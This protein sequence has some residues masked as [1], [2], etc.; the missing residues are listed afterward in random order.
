MSVFYVDACCD[1]SR[2]HIKTLGVE[3]VQNKFLLDKEQCVFDLESSPNL[4]DIYEKF[5]AGVRLEGECL[6]V[7]EFEQ[8]FDAAL[9]Q[10]ENVV[11]VH[12]SSVLYDHT[13]NAQ[14]AIQNL[15]AKYPKQSIWMFDT[16]GASVQSGLVCLEAAI[17]NKRGDV[18]TDILA[19]LDDFS[20]Q[21]AF[22]FY[23]NSFKNVCGNKINNLETNYGSLSLIKPLFAINE[24]GNVVC[25]NKSNGKKKAI[26]DL[27]EY[28]KNLGENVADFPIAIIHANCEKDALELRSKIVQLIG[29]DSKIWVEQ[30]GPLTLS[31]IGQGALGIA[32]H[33]KK[34]IN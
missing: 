1:L 31:Q 30:A 10:G 14:T 29:N 4:A 5:R 24:G 18:E 9:S 2:D 7:D 12:C 25:V 21:T 8:V 13:N 34:R 27:V 16:K 20:Q 33:A 15:K 28:V 17:R 32:F 6:T 3:T 23:A 11:Y 19:D 26:V 22:Y